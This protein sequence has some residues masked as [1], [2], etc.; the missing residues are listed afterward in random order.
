[1]TAETVREVFDHAARVFD[2]GVIFA[3]H[4]HGIR[5]IAQYGLA[6]GDEPPA[7]RVRRLWLP[8][9]EPSVISW[10]ITLR[11]T[12]RGKAEHNRWNEVLFGVLAGNWPDESVAIPIIVHKRVALVFYGDNEPHDLP[13]GST[14]ELEDRLRRVGRELEEGSRAGLSDAESAEQENA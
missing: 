10:A 5:G 13:V 12:F 9:D 6:E 7:Q 4:S 14:T 8:I 3:V 2:R 11:S 1:V